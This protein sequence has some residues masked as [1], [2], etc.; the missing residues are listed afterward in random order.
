[1]VLGAG[2]GRIVR[3]YMAMTLLLT[4]S[5]IAAGT[6]LGMGLSLLSPSM[7]GLV[8]RSEPAFL[9]Y[10]VRSFS[11][12]IPWLG[13]LCMLILSIAVSAISVRVSLG[14]SDVAN[15]LVP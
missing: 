2:R 9:D 10:Y 5:A 1:M 13:I 14:R 11:I 4:F 8:A 15:I 12:S 6:V 7:I 3:I